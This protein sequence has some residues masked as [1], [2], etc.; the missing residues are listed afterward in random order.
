MFQ[1]VYPRLTAVD[2]GVIPKDFH[3]ERASA[4]SPAATHSK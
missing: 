4:A 2:G 3:L 1:A